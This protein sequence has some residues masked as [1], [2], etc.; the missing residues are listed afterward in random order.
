MSHRRNSTGLRCVIAAASTAALSGT[1]LGGNTLLRGDATARYQADVLRTDSQLK[2]FP[3]V[4]DSVLATA[5]SDLSPMS[6]FDFSIGQGAASVGPAQSEVNGLSR[7]GGFD[8]NHGPP[9]DLLALGDGCSLLQWCIAS[10][11]LETGTQITVEVDVRF[12]GVLAASNFYGTTMPGEHRADA[13]GFVDVDGMTLYSGFATLDALVSSGTG[14]P[15]LTP[16]GDWSAG[17]FAATVYPSGGLGDAPGFELSDSTT[18]FLN[19]TVG[20]IFEILMCVET[21]ANIPGAL[22]AFAVAD[23]I[24][25]PWGGSYTLE[26]KFVTGAP[27]PVE[28]KLVPT[29]GGAALA[30]LALV[31]FAARRRR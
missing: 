7:V 22:E 23:F 19:L 4:T 2:P 18:L 10:D 14:P 11:S 1:A 20:S 26:G 27:A 16:G 6:G 29:P 15:T 9:D 3:V 24:G 31:G 30:G 13:S 28:F 12:R 21:G 5:I 17:E 25:D 8:P